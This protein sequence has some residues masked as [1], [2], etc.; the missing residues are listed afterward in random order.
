[1]LCNVQNGKVYEPWQSYG[2]S[3]TANIL[4]SKALA[5]RYARNGLRAY[6]VHPGGIWTNLGHHA[7]DSLKAW[8]K[9]L[10]YTSHKTVTH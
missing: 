4:Y 5:Q 2:Q 6:S 3:K 9:S 8:G 10:P 7:K 1:M